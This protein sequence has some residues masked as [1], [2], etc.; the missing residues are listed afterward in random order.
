MSVIS[1]SN[2]KFIQNRC[3]SEGAGYSPTEP[4]VIID[5]QL[6]DRSRVFELSDVVWNL[7][8]IGEDGRLRTEDETRL[9]VRAGGLTYLERSFAEEKPHWQHR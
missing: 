7:E 6:A 1:P 5:E 9:R 4:N 8:V 2:S 3:R